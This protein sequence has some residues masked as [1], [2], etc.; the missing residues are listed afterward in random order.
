MEGS[1]T[2]PERRKHPQYAAGSVP[3]SHPDSGPSASALRRHIVIGSW[4]GHTIFL[5]YGIFYGISYGVVG[6]IGF[7]ADMYLIDQLGSLPTLIGMVFGA[8]I[9]LIC[10]WALCVLIAS[11]G[12]ALVYLLKYKS[13]PVET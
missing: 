3:G 12:G 10:V 9:G 11:F 1:Y 5:T 7:F 6:G 2:G 13:F 4:L 8:F